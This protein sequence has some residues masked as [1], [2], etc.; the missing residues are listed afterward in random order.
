MREL[1]EDVL[2][3][4][5]I[6]TFTELV[7][8]PDVYKTYTLTAWDVFN[9][10]GE[11]YMMIEESQVE[12][13]SVKNAL[14]AVVDF[15][16]ENDEE[17]LMWCAALDREYGFEQ[18][19]EP[20]EYEPEPKNADEGYEDGEMPVEVKAFTFTEAYNYV[21][22]YA[23]VTYNMY[24]AF[25]EMSIRELINVVTSEEV[26]VAT[27][28][29]ER[30]DAFFAV[31]D[32][33]WNYPLGEL[34]GVADEAAEE[35]SAAFKALTV[36]DLLV[37]CE[38]DTTIPEDCGRANVD[39]ISAMYRKFF[40]YTLGYVYE[41]QNAIAE[42][43]T[44]TYFSLTFGDI[45][46]MSGIESKVELPAPIA[47]FFEKYDKC[48]VAD[49]AAFDEAQIA[50]FKFDAESASYD[51][52][53][54]E[55][56]PFI[57]AY[58]FGNA[59]FKNFVKTLASLSYAEMTEGSKVV[60]AL[61]HVTVAD[62]IGAGLKIG[63]DV[64]E[65]GVQI[66]QVIKKIFEQIGEWISNQFGGNTQKE[67]DFCGNYCFSSVGFIG[68]AAPYNDDDQVQLAD[69]LNRQFGDA[70]MAVSSSS[71][72]WC[73]NGSETYSGYFT[74]AGF[75]Y[76]VYQQKYIVTLDT[77]FDAS[78]QATQLDQ[79]IVYT[80]YQNY[81]NQF[82]LVVE[83]GTTDSG[84][85]AVVVNFDRIF[86][87]AGQTFE[88]DMFGYSAPIV[89]YEDSVAS[90]NSD[91]KG[92][93]LTFA[94]D[95]GN[96]NDVEWYSSVTGETQVG[97]CIQTYKEL[98]FNFEGYRDNEGVY[99]EFDTPRTYQGYVSGETVC[100][101]FMSGSGKDYE[102]GEPVDYDLIAYFN[103]K[104]T[105]NQEEHI[106]LALNAEF[107]NVPD[108]EETY[109]AYFF[110]KE[111][112]ENHAWI[113][114]DNM[115]PNYY[116]VEA[117]SDFDYVIFVRMPASVTEY[118]WEAVWNQTDD[119]YIGED[120]SGYYYTITGW[121]ENGGHSTGKWVEAFG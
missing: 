91:Y 84:Y 71:V 77:V 34:A 95:P 9:Y 10:C 112:P 44:A 109:V 104:G 107:W 51:A 83:E 47:A 119:L 48:T 116:I 120:H 8:E 50:A 21:R 102:T 72:V 117:P 101:V 79:P 15:F 67:S 5:V 24:C 100:I 39:A 56:M 23:F 106:Y 45:V 65:V 70:I 28:D 53:M 38:V 17:F 81:G 87:V 6:V 105:G 11:L 36:E 108:V 26:S 82:G 89:G 25:E 66:A 113:A 52:S 115:G 97:Y 1:L 14:R 94:N 73:P 13:S 93:I 46:Y 20:V 22:A 92:G 32:K 49:F 98:Y 58:D 12:V 41:N 35:L 27:F 78:F 2:S 69:E 96:T 64:Y 61:K 42:E 121:G 43:M 99:H 90:M 40:G 88:F 103:I 18:E 55:L 57:D 7:E 63:K 60:E 30:I 3:D 110:S 59:N 19:F 114:M 75:D 54:L 33:Y 80:C 86:S 62:T 16:E 37:M 29:N 76:N 4:F 31:V 118:T 85:Y 74:D 68:E 111:S